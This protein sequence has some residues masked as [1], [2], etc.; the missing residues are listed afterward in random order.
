MISV[1]PQN[2]TP[3]GHLEIHQVPIDFTRLKCLRVSLGLHWEIL[4]FF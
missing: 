3:I 4:F 2:P 1:L